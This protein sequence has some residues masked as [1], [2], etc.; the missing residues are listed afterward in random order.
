[1]GG[2]DDEDVG[3]ADVAV[4]GLLF[5]AAFDIGGNAADDAGAGAFAVNGLFGA[6]FDIGG[7]AADDAGA[8]AVAMDALFGVVVD[9]SGN[10]IEDLG[11]GAE[12]AVNGLFGATADIGGN[13]ELDG[14]SFFVEALP[15]LNPAV[16]GSSLF[17]VLPNPDT[18]LGAAFDIDE[19][20]DAAGL[21]S[22]FPANV[23]EAKGFFGAAFDIGGN[24]LDEE[25]AFSSFFGTGV[26]DV[27][28]KGLF[29]AA[30]DIGG[31]ADE[32]AVEGAGVFAVDE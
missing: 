22:V 17:V 27:V 5:G 13:A 14:T 8:G 31:N 3:A 9:M 26:G 16:V 30:F 15:K 7:K 2:N 10:T 21:G 1:M 19:K 32:D 24:A 23:F 12:L 25:V 4:N 20:N 29:G 11:A 18:E 6:A 28:A